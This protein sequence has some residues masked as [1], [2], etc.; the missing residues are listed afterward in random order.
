MPAVDSSLV[1]YPPWRSGWVPRCRPM[2]ERSEVGRP[3]VPFARI[4]HAPVA[5]AVIGFGDQLTGEERWTI[6][7]LVRC[8]A[9]VHGQA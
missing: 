6:L 3:V 8:F 4:K 9:G 7:L 5:I 2:L 1:A